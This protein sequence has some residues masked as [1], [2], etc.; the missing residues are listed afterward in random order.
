MLPHL[1]RNIILALTNKRSPGDAVVV[2]HHVSGLYQPGRD[3]LVVLNE[4]VAVHR[5]PVGR[6]AGGA[7][8]CLAVAVMEVSPR[9]VESLLI[10]IVMRS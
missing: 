2:M 7:G 4:L 9:S 6:A 10:L 1:R 5:E 3:V 8:V